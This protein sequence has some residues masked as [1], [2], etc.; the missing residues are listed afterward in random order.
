MQGRHRM[1]DMRDTRMVGKKRTQSSDVGGA[2]LSINGSIATCTR[3]MMW[4]YVSFVALFDEKTWN[5]FLISR[6]S[7]RSTRFGEPFIS[8]TKT[9]RKTLLTLPEA[10]KSL[11]LVSSWCSNC[12]MFN[13]NNNLKT[14]ENETWNLFESAK[15]CSEMCWGSNW[16]VQP[17]ISHHEG[18]S[19]SFQATNLGWVPCQGHGNSSNKCWK[20]QEGSK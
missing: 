10:R 6:F 7:Y 13:Q 2:D 18:L 15:L 5:L 16:S 17:I 3:C 12:R 14:S 11:P 1:A 9:S 8:L 20:F 19:E 4:Q